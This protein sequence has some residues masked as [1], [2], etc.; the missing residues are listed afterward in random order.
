MVFSPSLANIL[1]FDND[2]SLVEFL[3]LNLRSEGYDIRLEP[4]PNDSI[5]DLSLLN[6][7]NIVIVD[8]SKRAVDGLALIKHIKSSPQGKDVGLIYCSNF[9][10]ERTLIDAL[11]MG[12]D[13]CL[14]KPFS[15]RELLARLRA[16]YRRRCPFPDSGRSVL[17]RNTVK[18]KSMIVD[19]SLKSVSIEGQPINLSSTEYAILMFLL[20]NLGTYTSRMEI[21]RTVWPEGSSSNE[22]VVDTNISRL[23]HKLG[24][25]ADNLIN[26]TGLGYMLAE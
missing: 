20:Q 25:L 12:A 17:P 9:D 7:V 1:L 6:D 14:R 22:R 3:C 10:E 11:D 19:T 2:V 5:I 18:F 16:V 13:D 24:P 21:F 26:R 8:N 15:L 4:Y 23:R